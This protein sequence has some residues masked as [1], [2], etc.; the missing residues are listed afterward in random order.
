MMM[1]V[2]M[3][4]LRPIPPPLLSHGS[5]VSNISHRKCI[6]AFSLVAM[7]SEMQTCMRVFLCIFSG[8]QQHWMCTSYNTDGAK[9][10]YGWVL[11]EVSCDHGTR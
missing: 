2:M 9:Y 6:P 11:L 3:H 5:P 10:S 4:N 7:L 8:A 1:V